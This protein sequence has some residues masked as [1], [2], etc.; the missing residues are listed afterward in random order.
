M[1]LSIKYF[2]V[3]GATIKNKLWLLYHPN[4]PTKIANEAVF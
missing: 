1:T 4:E 2:L 3:M